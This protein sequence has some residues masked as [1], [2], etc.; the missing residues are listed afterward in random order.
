M[1]KK[2]AFVLILLMLF[3]LAS[4]SREE[5]KIRDP[6]ESI[7]S[8]L[9][10]MESYTAEATV[11]LY[12]NKFDTSFTVFQ[13]YSK[14]K[15]RLEVFEKEEQPDKIVVYDGKRSYVYFRKVDQIFVAE[16]E[17]EIPLFSMISSF[18]KNYF[19]AGGEIEKKVLDNSYLVTVPI[20][21]RNVVMYKEEMIFSK[22]DLIPVELRIF[23]INNELFAKITYKDFQ[24]NLKLQDDLFSEGT[25]KESMR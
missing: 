20:P 14:G 11:E 19:E 15:F 8:K 23:D 12:Y 3:L 22:K 4:C 21:E 2:R 10:K 6:F 9:S 17:K 18:A 5:K 13:F 24:Y 16:N 7:K 1:L 25:I